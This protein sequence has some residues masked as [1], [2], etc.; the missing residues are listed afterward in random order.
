MK[1]IIVSLA[2]IVFSLV[3]FAQNTE[4]GIITV[5]GKS[6]VKL[7]PEEISFT[8]N[9][10]VKDSNY[11]RCADMAVEK[12]AKIKALFVENGIDEDL[13]KA[14]S[15]SIR[16]VQRHDPQ[17][18]KMVF[19]GYEANIPLTLKTQRDY[20][21]NDLIFSIIKDN[22][23][24]NFNLSF[25]LSEEQRNAVKEKLIDLA[26]QDARDKA[27]IITKSAGVKLGTIKSIQYGDQRTIARM[28]D[29]ELLS[30]GSIAMKMQS[31][32]SITEVLSPDEIIMATN[33]IISWNL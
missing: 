5:E 1:R 33:I 2:L 28:N 20:E 14:S 18:R 16:E 24:S 29:R 10:S 31:E 25:G 17:L 11:S 13:I 6:T 7:V 30:S 21:K 8:V 32:S 27:E 3:T 9:L 15:Y 22:V 12:L 19:D 4:S 26:V 23:E